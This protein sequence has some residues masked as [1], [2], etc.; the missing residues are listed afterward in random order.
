MMSQGTMVELCWSGPP[1]APVRVP[2][3]RPHTK[4]VSMG[5][6]VV[7]RKA[8]KSSLPTEYANLGSLML[9]GEGKPE[10]VQFFANRNDPRVTSFLPH[11]RRG[12]LTLFA[13]YP[14]VFERCELVD[15]TSKESD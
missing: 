12:I 7:G 4:G 11:Q 15:T 13:R 1:I 2:I 14:K 5:M 6:Y 3:Y 9:A 8:P 10:E